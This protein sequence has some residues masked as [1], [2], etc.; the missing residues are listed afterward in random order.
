M[1][2]VESLNQEMILMFDSIKSNFLN[3]IKNIKKY[4]NEY[5]WNEFYKPVIEGNYLYFYI[6][7][8]S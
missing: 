4:N 7:S 3:S 1:E 8:S 5:I 2:N 6:Y